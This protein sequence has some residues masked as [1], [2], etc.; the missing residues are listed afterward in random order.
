SAQGP[1]DRRSPGFR[2]GQGRELT[3]VS[4]GDSPHAS[5]AGNAP[6]EVAVRPG[7]P[8][9]VELLDLDGREGPGGDQLLHVPVQA[10]A[11]GQAHHQPV[12]PALPLLY[13]Q[14]RAEAMLQEQ[15]LT[16]RPEYPVHFA[17]GLAHVLDAAQGKGADDAIE[18]AVLEGESFAAENPL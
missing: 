12:Q 18:G 2:V 8:F 3:T 5:F 13:A 15:E 6:V 10:A 9:E 14:L 4:Q 7:R 16:A 1:E 11:I 17:Q